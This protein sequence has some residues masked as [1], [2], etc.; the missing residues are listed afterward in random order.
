MNI[1]TLWLSRSV[2]I[3]WPVTLCTATPHGY[4]GYERGVNICML[5]LEKSVTIRWPV[6]LCTATPLGYLKQPGR[7]KFV[8]PSLCICDSVYYLKQS[9]HV[10]VL[11]LWCS[12]GTNLHYL[13]TWFIMAINRDM[14]ICTLWLSWS[15]TI[16]WPVTLCTVT[17]LG[18]NNGYERGVNICILLLEKSVTIRWPVTL[19]YNNGYERGVNICTL[20]LERSVTIRWPVTL[21]TV[22][23]LGYLKQPGHV[24]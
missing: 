19:W 9:G 7:E 21:C 22:T 1:C 3:M 11:S 18:Y 12:M 17:P 23:P 16:R 8:R 20:L 14:N 4:N 6:T 10:S 2:T 5:L 15:V 13:F 24:P